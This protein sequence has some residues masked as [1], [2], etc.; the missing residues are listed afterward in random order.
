MGA[1]WLLM[2]GA[3]L[4]RGENAAGTDRALQID[5]LIGSFLGHKGNRS[6]ICSACYFGKSTDPESEASPRRELFFNGSFFLK[7]WMAHTKGKS[8]AICSS[9]RKGSD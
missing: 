7:G 4:A 1:T 8:T 3:L 6:G 9:F 5:E 2:D